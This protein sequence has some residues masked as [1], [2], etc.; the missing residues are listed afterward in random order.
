MLGDLAKVLYAPHKAFKQIIQNPKYWGA[1]LVL[2]LFVA[3]QAAFQYSYYSKVYFEETNPDINSLG[4]WTLNSTMWTSQAV[5]TNNTGDFLN[6]TNYLYGLSSLQF[7]QV[8]SSS[9]S[10]RLNNIGT[11]DCGPN[12]YKNF[13]MRAKIVNP[14][15]VPQSVN[16][17]MYSS[18]DANYFRNDITSMFAAS[19][20]TTW[21]NLTIPV[22]SG[23][24]GWQS[25]GSPNWES[26][27]YISMDFGFADN[28]SITVRL[29]GVFFRGIFQTAIESDGMGFLFYVLQLVFTQF[30][31][32]WLILSALFFIIIKVLKGTITW[33]PLFIAVGFALIVMVVQALISIAATPTL[34]PV[35]L[36]VELIVSVPV[37]AVT[38]ANAL[39]PLMATFNTISSAVQLAA[40]V[41]LGALGAFVVRALMPEFSW[42]KCI[43]ASSGALVVTIILLR[44]LIGV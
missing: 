33:K 25:T 37:E 30:L 15:A 20:S 10:M 9:L 1:I 28:S 2:V 31:F 26:I 5:I 22:G 3:A 44:L 11:V 7:D 38:L 19:S 13:S 4:I 41:W 14:T 8:N 24:S 18:S 16:L 6:S 39:T 27:T 34:P 12:G 36:P 29:E 17:T 42:G 43:A 21:N 32:E 23:A 35:H 40:W